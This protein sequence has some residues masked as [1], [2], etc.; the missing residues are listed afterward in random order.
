MDGTHRKLIIR[1]VGRASGLTVDYVQ[2]RLY[3]TELGQHVIESSDLNGKKR[4]VVIGKNTEKP[5][6]LA[7]YLVRLSE[8]K[9]T[10]CKRIIMEF[11]KFNYGFK[12]VV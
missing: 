7:Q 10:L 12:L 11:S 9:Q 8:M 6:G 4:A 3:W 1:K 2:H 5:F